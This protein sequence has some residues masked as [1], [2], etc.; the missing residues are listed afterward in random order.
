MTTTFHDMQT[1]IGVLRLVGDEGR[2]ERIDLPNRASEPPESSW[3]PSNG[4]LPAALDEARR[5]IGQYF[6]GERRDFDLPLSAD[7]TDFQRQVWAELERIP[8][9]STV[10]YGE[11]AER[12]GRPTASRAVGAANGRN[13]LPV[14]VPCHRVV[15]ASGRLVGYGGGLDV[16]Q[17]LLELEGQ[18]TTAC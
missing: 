9:G 5:Q 3:A 13:P 12:I 7:G 16:K 1:P 18:A 2:I 6:A 11:I 17:A 8:Y 10:S 14:V 4:A 15:G